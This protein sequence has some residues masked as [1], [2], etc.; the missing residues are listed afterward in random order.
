[1]YKIRY[2][3]ALTLLLL[4]SLKTLR[5]QAIWATDSAVIGAPE[6]GM[7]RYHEVLAYNDPLMHL[8]FPVI[9][10]VVDRKVALLE[11]EGKDG[12]W[13]EGMFGHRFSIY[14][15][16]YY[17]GKLWQRTRFTLDISLQSIL[18]RD[19][20]SPLLPFNNKMGLGLDLLLSPL[21]NLYKEESNLLWTTLQLHHYS[22]GQA[23]T[24]FLDSPFKRNNY[25]SGNFSTNYFRGMVS[26]ANNSRNLFITTVGFQHDVDL[27]GPLARNTELKNYYGDDRLLLQ[28]N[29]VK[30]PVLTTR[31]IINRATSDRKRI[32]KDIRRQLGFRTD[33]EYILGDLSGFPGDQKHR[34]GWHTYLTYMPSVTNEIGFMLHTYLGRHY[35]NIRFDDVVFAAG[36]GL[37]VKFN[38]K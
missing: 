18:T 35:L 14:K 36:L 17:S 34:L 30:K 2:T 5:S 10:P 23:D 28:L 31:Q 6:Y 32:S 26:F 38:G 1:M 7:D 33:L 9:K 20:S 19:H 24:F 4:L 12:Y 27:G 3:I 37:Y 29:W 25:K 16:K 15:G 22:N 11:G 21:D 8:V 13:L